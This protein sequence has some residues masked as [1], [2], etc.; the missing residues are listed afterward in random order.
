MGK[1][2]GQLIDA[3]RKLHLKGKNTDESRKKLLDQGW[4]MNTID[5]ALWQLGFRDRKN[6][7]FINRLKKYGTAT[8]GVAVFIAILV[9][10]VIIDRSRLPEQEE[11]KVAG[12]NTGIVLSGNPTVSEEAGISFDAPSTWEIEMVADDE[13]IY[14]W[15]IEPQSNREVKKELEAKYS[16]GDGDGT[17]STANFALLNDPLVDQLTTV[18]I[19]VTK[20]PPNSIDASLKEWKENID[21]A[22]GQFG[23]TTRNFQGTLRDGVRGYAYESHVE[24]GE[25]N[26][27]TLELVFLTD[28][29]RVE[30]SAFPL[31]SEQSA[32]VEKILESLK[33]L[34]R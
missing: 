16:V 23:L 13:G 14:A 19:I 30:I 34:R 31:F 5:R 10:V 33:F 6:I 9:G 4:D 25:I 21:A 3:A 11:T 1:S 2:Y 18:N 17:E 24:L 29:S 7:Y 27:K 22:S 8:L 15:L 32:E 20:S 28:S 12:A 26:V